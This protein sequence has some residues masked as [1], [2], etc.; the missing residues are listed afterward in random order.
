[1][2]KKISINTYFCIFYLCLFKTISGAKQQ[3]FMT[4][5]DLI[6]WNLETLFLVEEEIPADYSYGLPVS[7]RH[8]FCSGCPENL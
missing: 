7:Q 3:N 6:L 4:I 1:M 5:K 2:L 8:S